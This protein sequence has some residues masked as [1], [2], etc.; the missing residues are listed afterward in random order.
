MSTMSTVYKE[1]A[2]SLLSG[3]QWR[4]VSLALDLAFTDMIRK[5]GF[6]RC[7]LLVMD[8]VL[9]HLDGQG[10]E[11]VGSVLRA[12]VAPSGG[13]G[14]GSG[15]NAK[16]IIA[17]EE[18]MVDDDDD[19]E[20]IDTQTEGSNNNEKKQKTIYS[21]R[22]DMERLEVIDQY[23]TILVILQDV[24]AGELEEAFD[25]IDIVVKRGETSRVVLDD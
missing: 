17:K 16:T 12:L 22:N 4:R 18:K 2:L 14:S 9:S 1:R 6:L 24:V 13:S 15:G 21:N 7:N 10:R 8:E 3:G 23:A 19:V 25:H 11:A 5:K 20:V